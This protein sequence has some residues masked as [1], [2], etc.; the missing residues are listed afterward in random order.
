MNSAEQEKSSNDV[1]EDC[2]AVVA[3]GRSG[4]LKLFEEILAREFSDYRYGR[5]HR[6]TVDAYALQHPDAYMRSGKSFAAHLTGMCAALEYEDALALNQTIQKWLSTNPKI[7]KP[8]RL[9]AVRGAITITHIHHASNPEAHVAR[10]REWAQEVWHA[11]SEHHALARQLIN[12]A[13]GTCK[14]GPD[15][16]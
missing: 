14:P 7:E 10:V 8:V 12:E 13:T 4:C 3:E 1:C 16:R 11:W 9:P 2:G 15:A 6:L 5:V